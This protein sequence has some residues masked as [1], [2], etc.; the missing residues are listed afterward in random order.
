M[1]SIVKNSKGFK[2]LE[3]SS[4][5][6]KEKI[7]GLG[8]CDDCNSDF[9]TAFYIAV[10]NHCYCKKCY[11]S[12]IQRAIVYSSDK[13]IEE[14]NFAWILRI[15]PPIIFDLEHQFQVFLDKTGAISAPDNQKRF[16][17]DVFFVSFH[18]FMELMRDELSKLS[19]EKAVETLDKLF[20]QAELY[21]DKRMDEVSK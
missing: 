4:K 13:I 2:V 20:E 1:S 3:I 6:C 8:I 10:L 7:G 16:A 19:D 5:E 9:E 17:K 12:W 11:D 14:K 18:Q 15:V 21:F